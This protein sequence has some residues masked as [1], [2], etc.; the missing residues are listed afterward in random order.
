MILVDCL[1]AQTALENQL[2]LLAS[3]RDYEAIAKV[4]PLE[5]V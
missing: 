5:L 4:R 2:K 3:D 1:I